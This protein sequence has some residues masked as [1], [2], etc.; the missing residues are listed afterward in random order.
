MPPNTGTCSFSMIIFNVY[1]LFLRLWSIRI[2]RIYADEMAVG[3]AVE[4]DFQNGALIGSETGASSSGTIPLAVDFDHET[5]A[6]VTELPSTSNQL[7][8]L[9]PNGDLDIK[10]R[11]EIGL[12]EFVESGVVSSDHSAFV[13]V[14]A[15]LNSDVGQGVEFRTTG[16]QAEASTS[17]VS[18]VAVDKV[19]YPADNS[20][21]T[22]NSSRFR[23]RFGNL[24]DSFSSGSLAGENSDTELSGSN[25]VDDTSTGSL[26]IENGDPELDGAFSSVVSRSIQACN[27]EHL[28]QIIEDAKNN[29]VC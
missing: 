1:V 18:E 14:D 25:L 3:N 27:I 26:A 13:Q 15:K 11:A 17:A 20:A 23:F 2:L 19:V 29:K 6:P 9:M 8:D 21:I 24:D 5:S 12:S 7:T 4:H 16:S 10:S 28:E 22:Q